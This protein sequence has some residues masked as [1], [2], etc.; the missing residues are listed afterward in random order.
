MQ[1]PE[2]KPE[3]PEHFYEKLVLLRIVR[4]DPEH[5]LLV[6]AW[7]NDYFVR[8]DLLPGD[9]GWIRC[10]FNSFE[11][12]MKF[13]A[14]EDVAQVELPEL[15]RETQRRPTL[16]QVGDELKTQGTPEVGERNVSTNRF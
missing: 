2:E 10:C 5:K 3:I 1:K 16:I 6:H 7:A 4:P 9:S 15:A 13:F 11:F 14:S 8:R 12:E